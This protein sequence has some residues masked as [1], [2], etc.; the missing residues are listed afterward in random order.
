MLGRTESTDALD[1]TAC[2]GGGRFRSNSTRRSV[3]LGGNSARS[4]I[5]VFLQFD[6]RQPVCVSRMEAL[7][8]ALDSCWHWTSVGTGSAVIN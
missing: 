4:G 2:E 5:D 8:L 1:W 6:R 7:L 3:G